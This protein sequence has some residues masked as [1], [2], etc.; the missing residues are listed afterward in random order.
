LGWPGGQSARR[1]AAAGRLDQDYPASIS[2][3][4][5]RNNSVNRFSSSLSFSRPHGRPYIHHC[6]R[7]PHGILGRTTNSGIVHADIAAEQHSPL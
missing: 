2:G 3:T 4:P 6:S 1:I 7:A 5:C